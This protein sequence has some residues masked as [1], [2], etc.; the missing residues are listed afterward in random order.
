MGCL[1]VTLQQHPAAKLPKTFSPLTPSQEEKMSAV[2][3]A[4]ANQHAHYVLAAWLGASKIALQV[5]QPP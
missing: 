5:H 1:L 4:A 3:E 2:L